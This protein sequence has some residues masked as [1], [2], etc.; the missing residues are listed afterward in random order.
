M[1]TQRISKISLAGALLVATFL[2]LNPLPAARADEVLGHEP[3]QVVVKLAP[4]LDNDILGIN[5]AYGTITLE[6]LY[7]HDDIFL[8]Q[9][10]PESSAEALV[11][12]MAGDPRLEYAEL[13]YLNEYPEEGSTDRIYGW[14]D[15]DSTTFR[16]QDA[17]QSMRLES[18][19]S[20]DQGEG[21]TVAVLDTGVQLDHPEFAGQLVSPGFDFVDND[22]TP[23]DEA[24]GV[25][26]DGDGRVDEAYGHGTHVTGIVLLVAPQAQIM[27]LRV[28]NSDG[29]GNDFRTAT[30]I[31][32]AAYSG[33][34]VINLSLGTSQP[35]E[36]L[37]EAVEEAAGLGVVVVAA[38][39]NLNL[40]SPQ[41]PAA[42]A[43]ALAVTSV[44]STRHKSSF[45]SYGAWVDIAA[46]GEDVY[47]TFPVSGYAWWSGTSMA[48]PF[49]A[50]QVALLLSAGTGL[51]LDD[52]G[53]LIGGTAGSLD[54][55]NPRYRGLLG[56]GEIDILESLE[57]LEAGTWPTPEH[58]LFA[59]CNE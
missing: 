40:D 29:R 48:T 14:S 20:L 17:S 28:L 35:S 11:E 16:S 37:R 31:V 53:L 10:P 41:Y 25:D 15:G 19:H 32:Y 5:L 4:L 47:S 43:C 9:A 42:E 54:N 58:N 33:A 7:A 30:A 3:G 6:I 57:S 36:L 59:G 18:V 13:N 52:V 27:P 45:A 12:A 46:L 55:G 21:M 24:N 8:L 2:S 26:D 23:D 44:D 22:L 34:G 51:S 49:V 38:A 39:G 1:T 50:G 56:A